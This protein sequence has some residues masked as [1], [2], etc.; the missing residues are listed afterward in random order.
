M[1]KRSLRTILLL[2]MAVLT[3]GS[4][5]AQQ[6]FLEHSEL[7][8]EVGGMNYVGDLNGQNVF[9]KPCWGYG[10]GYRYRFDDRWSL[11]VGGAYGHIEGGN[12]DAIAMRNLSF[13]SHLWEATARAEFNFL[14][15]GFSDLQWRFSPYIFGGIGLMGFNPKAKYINANG[16]EE[17]AELRPLRTEGQ[18]S[19]E[20]GDRTPYSLLQV[21]IPFGMG[22]RFS[23]NKYMQ[24]MVE[25]GYR[26]TFTDYLDDV[27]KTYVGSELLRRSE[28]GELAAR[29]ADR[30]AE[31]EGGVENAVGIKRGDDSLDDGYGYMNI[32][33]T[34]SLDLLMGWMF[35]KRCNFNN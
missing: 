27:S 35:P 34:I 21:V 17:W 7:V 25:Y 29:L 12:P 13:K 6:K 24:V 28:G 5:W 14:P 4:L 9:S 2:L 23:P 10:V 11:K 33:V 3:G 30:S 18:G 15:Y 8:L 20:Y 32:S 26:K 19:S 22:I 31:L 1:M 16:E